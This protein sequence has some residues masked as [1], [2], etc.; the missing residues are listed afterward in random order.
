MLGLGSRNGALPGRR[1]G[2]LWC[3]PGPG[4][5]ANQ[6]HIRVE[7]GSA[8]RVG[9]NLSTHNTVPTSNGGVYL[10]ALDIS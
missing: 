4:A 5:I 2:G 3:G 8:E 6:E 9:L 10:G 1:R 7:P